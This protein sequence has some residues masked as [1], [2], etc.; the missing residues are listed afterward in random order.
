MAIVSLDIQK[1]KDSYPQFNNLT[2]PVLYRLFYF[3]EAILDNTD[4]SLVS[5][6][7]KR[8]TLLYLLMAHIATIDPVISDVNGNAGSGIVGR[9]SSGSEG[10]VSISTDYAAM[11]R[12]SAWYMQS[13]YGAM[14]WEMTK[15]YRMFRYIPAPA[16]GCGCG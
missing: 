8:E 4:R 1:F 11:S 13:Q 5:D 12:S 3:A 6:L 16:R 2:E 10:S 9:V 15:Q 14:Y 7:N